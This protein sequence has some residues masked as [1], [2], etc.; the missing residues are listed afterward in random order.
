MGS[1]GPTHLISLLLAVAIIAAICG[2]IASAVVRR[3]KRRARGFF[4]LGFL[5]GFIASPI[6]RRRRRG[7]N[8]LGAV[9][10]CADVRPLTADTSSLAVSRFRRPLLRHHFSIAIVA[11]AV[12]L[13]DEP[14]A[15]S[16]TGP[17]VDGIGAQLRLR[18]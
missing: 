15:T 17:F 5:C 13:P 3:N 14:A 18:P 2:F 7:L 9:A 16:G 6:L 12:A 4:L 8:V 11:A 1:V 10:R